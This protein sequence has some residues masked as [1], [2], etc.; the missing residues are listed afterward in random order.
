MADIDGRHYDDEQVREMRRRRWQTKCQ[1]KEPF[2]SRA[3]AEA[4]ARRRRNSTY[5]C[6]GCG[7]WHVGSTEWFV[8]KSAASRR[9]GKR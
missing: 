4:V 5:K 7:K 9:R 2:E 6:K 8:G 1:G 3:I